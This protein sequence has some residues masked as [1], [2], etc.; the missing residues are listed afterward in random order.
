MLQTPGG[1]KALAGDRG[2]R[3]DGSLGV[4]TWGEGCRRND[5]TTRTLHVLPSRSYVLRSVSR[6]RLHV[7]RAGVDSE[8]VECHRKN[9]ARAA[10]WELC[11]AERERLVSNFTAVKESH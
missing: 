1:G 5:I 4:T 7:I 6:W 8:S 2:R 11:A 9:A 10:Q 3:R